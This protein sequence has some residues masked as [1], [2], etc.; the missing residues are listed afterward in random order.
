M[1]KAVGGGEGENGRQMGSERNGRKSEGK[2][3]ELGG[4][5]LWGEEIQVASL[6][7]QSGQ[8]D[9]GDLRPAAYPLRPQFPQP[10]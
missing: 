1:V 5:W 6:K 7:E 9:S 4:C 3:G 2:E 10:S 8:I